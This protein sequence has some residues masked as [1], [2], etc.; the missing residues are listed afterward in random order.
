MYHG[1]KSGGPKQK[2]WIENAAVAFKSFFGKRSG[3]PLPAAPPDA[4]LSEADH[5]ASSSDDEELRPLSPRVLSTTPV[6]WDANGRPTLSV[7]IETRSPVP[8]SGDEDL[9]RRFAPFA[10]KLRS[11]EEAIVAELNDAQGTPVDLG[12]Y[13]LPDPEKASQA[14]RPSPLFNDALDSL[15]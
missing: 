5:A 7:R 13:Y 11:Q 14:M 8:I 3:P 6:A 12:G 10:E 1:R 15:N 4:P 9:Q 2:K